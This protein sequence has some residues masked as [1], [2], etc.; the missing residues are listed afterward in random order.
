MLQAYREGK[1]LYV[2]IASISFHRPY[3]TCLE[4]FPKNCPI[5]Q[6]DG[7]WVYAK[8]KNGQDDGKENFEDLNYDNINP[9]DYDYDKLSDG[10]T[11]V[12][13]EGKEYRS[14]SKK[15]L[16][17]I[18][19]GRGEKSIAEQLGCSPEE[20]K[21]IKNNV[22]DAFPRIKI[23]ERESAQM[24]RE[25]GYVTTLWN[26]RRRLPDY[27][28]PVYEFH[29]INEN[30]EIVKDMKVPESDIEK[31]TNK[32]N[33]TYWKNR[34]NYINELRKIGIL[35]IDNSSKIAAAGRQII[36]SRVQGSAADMSKLAIIK[37]RNDEELVNRGVRP[38]IPVHDEIL[39]ETPLRYAKY[40]KERFK[41]DMETAAK[42][43]LTI[44][45][46]CDVVTTQSW[47]SDELDL[48]E[49][50]KGLPDESITHDPKWSGL[51]KVHI[52]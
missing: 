32:L 16:L 15:I 19:Y 47:Y 50:L 26:R 5:K 18:M 30:G 28:L 24:V 2:E 8:L 37:I 38:I 52:D 17:G 9:D 13:K 36:N 33:N 7:K 25:K 22:Y 31:Y 48:N 41:E 42:P 35:V 34:E 12:F 23:F 10:E 4:H 21:E 27:N 1:D 29:Y 20:A 45:V 11:D 3:K 43:T 39:I 46:C 49:E 44:P 14:Q 40:V 6:V 51:A